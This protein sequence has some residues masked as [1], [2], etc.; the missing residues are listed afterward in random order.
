MDKIAVLGFGVVGSGTVEVFYN[1]K[2]NIC[3]KAGKLIDVFSPIRE[4]FM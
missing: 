4:D 3:K 2:S 1:N